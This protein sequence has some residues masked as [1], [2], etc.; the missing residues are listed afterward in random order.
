[1]LDSLRSR[2][3]LQ[4]LAI[5]QLPETLEHQL[6]ESGQVL[7][8]A[9]LNEN[10]IIVIGQGDAFS[11]ATT[12]VEELID[13]SSMERPPLPGVL[14]K[15][16]SGIES[17]QRHLQALSKPGDVLLAIQSSRQRTNRVQDDQLTQMCNFV[18][19]IGMKSIL[20]GNNELSNAS[21]VDCIQMKLNYGS[22]MNYLSSI[23]I[24]AL[25]LISLVDYHLFEQP[26]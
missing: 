9:L 1:M 2:F 26:I 4:G 5:A 15:G 13:S 11:T 18:Q 25:T 8:D 21:A 20:L 23:S 19:T 3:E 14:I 6:I 17:A 12:I 24:I 16:T 10:K 22:R 7:A